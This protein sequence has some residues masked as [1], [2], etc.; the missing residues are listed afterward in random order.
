MME[1]MAPKNPKARQGRER[2]LSDEVCANYTAERKRYQAEAW[3]E[4]N[5]QAW[6]IIKSELEKDA[7]AKR[8]G[9]IQHAV[10]HVRKL[11]LVDIRGN[12][13]N[14]NNS[15]RPALVRLF[16]EQHPEA[17]PYIEIRKSKA[18]AAFGGD[19]NAAR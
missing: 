14:I 10:E 11:D 6:G 8:R 9:S 18:D 7:K 2:M 13:V 17:R 1:M 15:I 5:P 4:E 19:S 3:I 12:A 16:L